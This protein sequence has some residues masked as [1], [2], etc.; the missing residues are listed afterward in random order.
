MIKR[1]M[2][3][4]RNLVV[5]VDTEV[6]LSNGQMAP[7]INFDNAATTPPLKEV[8][9]EINNFSKMY[10]SVHRGMGYKS[11]YTT[12]VYEECRDIVS[13][14]LNIDTKENTVIFVKNATEG[15]N[16][17]SYSLHNKYGNCVVLS[18]FMEH[19]SNDLPRRKYFKV[20]YIEVDENGELILDDIEKKLKKYK[21][22][23]K[24]VTVSGASNVTGYKNDVYKIAKIVHSYGACIVVDG[25]QLIPHA[26]LDMLPDNCP[27]HIDYTT[28]SAHKMYAPFGGGAL[29]G[30]KDTF[31][32]GSPD[33]VGGGTIDI[34]THEFIKW[35]NPPEKDEAGSPN[36]F[37][38]LGLAT[39]IK[40]IKK[41]GMEYI[42]AYE[43]NLLEYAYEK[44]KR[45][46]NCTIY[47]KDNVDR[48]SLITF[49]I[50]GI[51]HMDLAKLLSDEGAIG[52]RTGC[53]CAQPYVAKLL[54][55]PM[56][57]LILYAKDADYKRKGM[58]RVSLSFYNTQK[59]IDRFIEVLSDIVKRYLS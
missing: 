5:G 9:E 19:H 16:I 12:Y 21:G 55:I 31:K 8:M 40:V 28:F 50:E 57:E 11:V 26:G 1:C 18:T 43:K 4:Y 33:Y 47:S 34:V 56:K 59:E 42:D 32:I 48:V 17:L 15:L 6:P 30:P 10:S 38:A 35:A 23:V 22:T 45:V 2:S 14:F 52:V 36:V 51:Y 54:Q 49:N 44:L 27:E 24:I 20:D 29:V 46:D 37:G 58:V 39:S 7:Y 53:F 13:Q 3:N 41:I 25:A